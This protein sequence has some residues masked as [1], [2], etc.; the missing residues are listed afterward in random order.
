M[1]GEAHLDWMTFP[2]NVASIRAGS[3]PADTNAALEETTASSVALQV[4]TEGDKGGE[5]GGTENCNLEPTN[6]LRD[7]T[8]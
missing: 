1:H 4:G 3:I 6:L 8:A 2:T 5:T 7:A